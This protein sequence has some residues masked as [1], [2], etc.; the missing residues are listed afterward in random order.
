[1]NIQ[2]LINGEKTVEAVISKVIA[3]YQEL[4]GSKAALDV[5]SKFPTLA[6]VT[7]EIASFIPIVQEGISV[8]EL[9]IQYG[10]L[11]YKVGHAIN[12]QPMDFGHPPGWLAEKTS[13][14]PE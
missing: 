11:M 3:G 5:V 6:T 7:T 10:P 9:L 13:D 8:A 4:T 1:M 14:F 12:V 2:T